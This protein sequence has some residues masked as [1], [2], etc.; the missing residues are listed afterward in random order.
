VD[1]AKGE[2]VKILCTDIF[3]QQLKEIL[4]EVL[5][6]GYEVTKNFKMYLD[7]VLINMPTKAAKYKKSVFFDDE[8]I[9][10]IVHQGLIIPFYEDKEAEIFVLLG[11]VKNN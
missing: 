1:E 3:E 4:E 7:T 11:I 8:N 10:D 6:N 2:V 9:K 5:E